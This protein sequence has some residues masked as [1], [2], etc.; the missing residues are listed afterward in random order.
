MLASLFQG[1]DVRCVAADVPYLTDFRLANGRGAY[2]LAKQTLD[3]LPEEQIGSAWKTLG[4]IDTISHASRLTLPVLL[5][6]GSAD[7]I[8]PPETVESLFSRLPSTK[9]YTLLEG[10]GHRYTTQF[11]P[12]A[13]A[14]FRLFA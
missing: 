10:V 8:C 11:I 9:S 12:L 14:W 4:L 2:Y 13:T 5:T 6:A 3:G 7:D 1:K